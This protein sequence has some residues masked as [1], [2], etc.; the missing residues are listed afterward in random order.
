M[1]ENKPINQ[2]NNS[3]T[4]KYGK[5]Y[6]Q[7]VNE[8]QAEIHIMDLAEKIY[9]EYQNSVPSQLKENHWHI[10]FRDKINELYPDLTLE[11]QIKV[12]V[13]MAANTSYTVVGDGSIITLEKATRIHDKCKDLS[14]SS[15][16][17]HCARA[18][19]DKEYNSFIKGELTLEKITQDFQHYKMDREDRR[20]KGWCR[21]F[22]GF[23]QYR[24]LIE[25]ENSK[26]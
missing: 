12:S 26:Q 25:S 18:M 11:E 23:I 5:E 4:I 13:G 9:D 21:N 7:A 15:V 8:G 10:P 17:E 22:K 6:W 16:F 14:H 2:A 1:M 3:D 20:N 24:H 19:S